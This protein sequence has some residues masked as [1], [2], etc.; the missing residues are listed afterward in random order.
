MPLKLGGMETAQADAATLTSKLS[1]SVDKYVYVHT[2]DLSQPQ[3]SRPVIPHTTPFMGLASGGSV[4]GPT[5]AMLGESGEEFVVP[6]GGALVKSTKGDNGNNKVI[7][8]NIDA[9]GAYLGLD[10]IDKL[11]TMVAEEILHK[12]TML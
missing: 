10:S 7:N 2:I 12:T 8:V 5:F 1:Q 6:R 4:S 9:R 3:V 11:T